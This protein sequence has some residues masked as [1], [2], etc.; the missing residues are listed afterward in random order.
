MKINVFVYLQVCMC[1]WLK[2]VTNKFSDSW[3]QTRNY[4]LKDNKTDAKHLWYW[5]SDMLVNFTWKCFLSNVEEINSLL[6][7]SKNLKTTILIFCYLVPTN[8]LKCS[9]I[10]KKIWFGWVI[11]N[12]ELIM[13]GP[14]ENLISKLQNYTAHP[15]TSGQAIYCLHCFWKNLFL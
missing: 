2:Y 12:K 6:L 15:E 5:N 14:K 10:C 4:M 8:Q 9:I 11:M 3:R 13:N 1:V 7:F